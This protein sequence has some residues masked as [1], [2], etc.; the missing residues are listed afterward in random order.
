M[1]WNSRKR[2]ELV[3]VLLG[4]RSSQVSPTTIR[5]QLLGVSCPTTIQTQPLGGRCPTTTQTQSLRG[6]STRAFCPTTTWTQSLGELLIWAFVLP[7][8]RLNRREDARPTT[9][10]TQSLGG[11]FVNHSSGHVIE[12]ILISHPSRMSVTVIENVNPF[13]SNQLHFLSILFHD[14]CFIDKIEHLI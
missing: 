3:Q 5:T 2:W 13:Q 6:L 9:I 8:L 7:P 14:L 1:T 10:R 4:Y 11:P 12:P